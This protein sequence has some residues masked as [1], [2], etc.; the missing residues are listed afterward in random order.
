MGY[1]GRDPFKS[2]VIVVHD[3]RALLHWAAIGVS[4]NVG[5]S[6]A[7]EISQREGD[8]GIIKSTADHIKFHL[9]CKPVF[10]EG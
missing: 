5:G 9:P 2:A 8:P 1:E 10:K 4:M 6:Y 7:N 3:L